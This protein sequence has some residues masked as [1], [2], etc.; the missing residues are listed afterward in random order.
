MYQPQ[1][2]VELSS[3]AGAREPCARVAFVKMQHQTKAERYQARPCSSLVAKVVLRGT[4]IKSL[5][6]FRPVR[7]RA[8]PPAAAV[9]CPLST[10]L[11]AGEDS[12]HGGSKRV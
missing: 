9:Q 12:D 7:R 5:K 11:G 6:F 1:R 8:V 2:F 4:D 10:Y 3:G